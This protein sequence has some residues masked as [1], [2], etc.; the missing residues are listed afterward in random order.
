MENLFY[1]SDNLQ[2]FNP[3]PVFIQNSDNEERGD[4]IHYPS[5]GWSANISEVFEIDEYGTIRNQSQIPAFLFGDEKKEMRN[6]PVF[7]VNFPEAGQFKLKISNI[8]ENGFLRISLDKQTVLEAALPLGPGE[9][10]WETS[11]YNEDWDIYQGT[12]NK[13]YSVDIPAGE[14]II[15][16][17]NTGT[18]WMMVEYYS[19][20]GCRNANLADLTV[21]GFH[22]KDDTYL[23]IRNTAY[24]W[25]SVLEHGYP[26][27]VKSSFMNLPD[28]SNGEYSIEF[29]DTYS[30]TVSSMKTVNVSS[31]N[32]KLDLPPVS[33]DAAIKIL[34][35]N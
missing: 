25:K 24:F 29:W 14:H 30:G 3:V 4:L 27:V 23:W 2:P 20:S 13:V 26:Q 31:N 1:H 15:K 8:S 33:K 17:E 22:H 11:T 19:F 9:G 10:P 6:P 12:Y 32:L 35:V 34:K 16:V 18:D 21:Q 28:I 7:K 5:K